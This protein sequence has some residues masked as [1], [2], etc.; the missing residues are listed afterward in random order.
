VKVILKEDV[1][2]LGRAGVVVNVAGGYGRNFLIP[3]K[4]A[5][6]ATGKNLKALE[7]E[8]RVVAEHQRKSRQGAEALAR[9][10]AE[11]TVTLTH[12]AGEEGKL[13]GAVTSREIGEALSREGIAVEKRQILLEEPIKQLGEYRVPVKLHPEVTAEL[14]VWVVK[15]P[16]PH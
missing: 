14:Q 9:R 16:A 13:F 1:E 8:K 6:V 15:A 2:K 11:T 3:R 10:I 5:V 4:L 7:H 12:L